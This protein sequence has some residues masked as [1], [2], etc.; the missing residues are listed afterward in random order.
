[1]IG[2]ISNKLFA[3]FITMMM[4]NSSQPGGDV[5]MLRRPCERKFMMKNHSPLK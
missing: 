4:P 3:F 5:A 1:M 2:A